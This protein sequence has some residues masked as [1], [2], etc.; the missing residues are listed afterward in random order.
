ML[1]IFLKNKMDK[2]K[3][4]KNILKKLDFVNWDR[5]FGEEEL[6]FFGWINRKEDNYKDFVTILFDE[7]GLVVSYATSSAEY[8]EKIAEILNLY[9]LPC[10]RVEYFCDLDNII[11]EDKTAQ[12]KVQ[13]G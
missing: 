4:I 10:N 2:R 12:L 5:Y 13:R 9:H 1:P 11:K 7:K 8:T 3:M 6:T